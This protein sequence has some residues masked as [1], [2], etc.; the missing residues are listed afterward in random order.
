MSSGL[1]ELMD[2]DVNKYWQSKGKL[3]HFLEMYFNKSTKISEIWFYLDYKQDESYCPNKIL[4]QMKNCNG[5]LIDVLYEFFC[6]AQGWYKIDIYNKNEEGAIIDY[7]LQTRYIKI[8]FLESELEG[9]DIHL[10]RILIFEP[11]DRE[12]VGD[13][14]DYLHYI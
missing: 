8:I 1:K 3:P 14:E 4:I 12:V 5:E 2:E 7:Y 9:K 13:E 10:R 6:Q 11:V